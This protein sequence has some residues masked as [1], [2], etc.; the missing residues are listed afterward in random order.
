MALGTGQLGGMVNKYGAIAGMAAA[1]YQA[2]GD[3]GLD[4]LMADAIAITKGGF[5][6]KWKEIAIG[7]AAI[8]AAPMI[9][10]KVPN[11]VLKG[12]VKFVLNYYGYSQIFGALRSGA[13]YGGRG[14]VS[15]RRVVA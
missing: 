15:A 4:G 7:G 12:V 14:F 1:A 9:A 13:G 2:Y 5:I 8:I 10:A 3:R 6:Q 11:T